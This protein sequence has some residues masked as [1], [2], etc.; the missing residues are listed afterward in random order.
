MYDDAI[1]IKDNEL[2]DD[3][4][5]RFIEYMDLHYFSLRGANLNSQ[6]SKAWDKAI[7]KAYKLG[8]L[9][10]SDIVRYSG[11]SKSY[12]Y[13]ILSPTIRT[14]KKKLISSVVALHRQGKTI[15]EI[16]ELVPVR[17]E[18]TLE[19][20]IEAVEKQPSLDEKTLNELEL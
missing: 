19:R 14:A 10:I 8:N 16:K 7:I 13:K 2:V 1:K 11:F 18:R 6:S 5:H 4:E 3:I 12:I 9:K 20:Y 15:E 17:H